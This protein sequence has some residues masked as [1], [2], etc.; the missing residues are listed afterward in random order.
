MV[1]TIIIIA[2]F[3][4]EKQLKSVNSKSNKLKKGGDRQ[5]AESKVKVPRYNFFLDSGCTILTL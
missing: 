3:H 2:I 1:T 4:R 5:D